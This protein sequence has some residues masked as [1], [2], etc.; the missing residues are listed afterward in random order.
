MMRAEPVEAPAQGAVR[1]DDLQLPDHHVD[2]LLVGAQTVGER[3]EHAG[4]GGHRIGVR[5][6]RAGG[7]G[8]R[9][10]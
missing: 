3:V 9:G 10:P 5:R 6:R 8:T 2:Q 4:D 1:G 7:V